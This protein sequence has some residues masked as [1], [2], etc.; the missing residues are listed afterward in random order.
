M[1]ERPREGGGDG[2]GR[3]PKQRIF[4]PSIFFLPSI[5]IHAPPSQMNRGLAALIVRSLARARS[6]SLLLLLLSSLTLFLRA[7][8]RARALTKLI[9]ATERERDR[10][11][12]RHRHRHTS[13]P[14]YIYTYA[15]KSI[16]SW[17]KLPHVM[18]SSLLFFF[19]AS[20]VPLL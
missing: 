2:G 3:V 6:L 17:Y 18:S 7:H 1:G 9:S 19:F 20:Q 12:H 16:M 11:R 4:S 15:A 5:C 8:A 10:L 14:I 13:A